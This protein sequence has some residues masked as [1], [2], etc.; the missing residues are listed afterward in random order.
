MRRAIIL[1]LA[2]CAALA[3]PLYAEPA[4]PPPI[5]TEVDAAKLALAREVVAR[6]QADPTEMI[7]AM[8]GPIAAMFDQLM[9]QEG[10]TAPDAAQILTNEVAIPI[11]LG[12]Y[13]ELLNMQAFTYATVLT[14]EDLHAIAAFYATPAGQ[15]FVKAKP[16]I[17]QASLVGMRQWVM[18]LIPEVQQ[19]F[20]EAAKAHGW[21]LGTHSQRPKFN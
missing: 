6:M 9:R 15:R 13:D 3:N 12:H 10:V 2:V 1:G 19:K 17:A 20:V 14:E 16:Q 4:A 8:K 18:A 5:A 11:L 21:V 7:T